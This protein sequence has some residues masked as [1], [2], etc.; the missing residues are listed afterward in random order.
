MS[1]FLDK[2]KKCGSM[3]AKGTPCPNCHYSEK[4]QGEGGGGGPA[5]MGEYRRRHRIHIR[6]YAIFMGLILA[7]GLLGAGTGAIWWR[8][9]GHGVPGGAGLI[10]VVG[11][12]LLSL[13][14][15]VLVPV[16]RIYLPHALHCPG[17]EVRL[18]EMKLNDGCC[19][20]CHARLE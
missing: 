17:C 9:I 20:G 15:M 3:I 11:L 12:A 7:A 13:L 2:C 14:A 4:D 19:P 18:D 6:N 5:L 10:L 16:A 8:R 1:S